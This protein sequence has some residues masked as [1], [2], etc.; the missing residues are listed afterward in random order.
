MRRLRLAPQRLRKAPLSPG[1]LLCL[2]SGLLGSLGCCLLLLGF[3]LGCLGCSTLFLGSSLLCLLGG[4]CFRRLFLRCCLGSSRSCLFLCL[5]SLRLFL[6]R[7][8]FLLLRSFCRGILLLPC[9]YGLFPRSRLRSCGCFS[10]FGLLCSPGFLLLC[11]GHLGIAA[12]TLPAIL[13]C[14]RATIIS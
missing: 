10:C 11:L 12:V 3:G 6:G 2:L 5:G 4:P 13:A 7:C 9:S 14:A 8:I 1:C